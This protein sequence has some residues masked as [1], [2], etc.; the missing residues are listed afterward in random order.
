M[1]KVALLAITLL[2]CLSAISYADC[3]YNGVSYQTGTVVNG[4]TCQADGSWD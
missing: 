3:F 2:L 1:K 4:L